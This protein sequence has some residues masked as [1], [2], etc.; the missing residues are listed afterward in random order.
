MTSL[1]R[2]QVDAAT[3]LKP[4]RGRWDIENRLFWV[5]DVVFKED[6]SRIR[7]GT[8]Y[9]AMSTFRNAGITLLRALKVPNLTAALRE[10]AL[11]LNVL[12]HRLNIVNKT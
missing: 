5:R 11:K 4:W 10:N 2:D 8:A 12:L 6:L 1:S 3:L 7:S 9:T